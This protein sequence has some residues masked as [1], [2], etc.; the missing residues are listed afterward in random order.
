[1]RHQPSAQALMDPGHV[2]GH[3]LGTGRTHG[4]AT[5]SDGSPLQQLPAPASSPPEIPSTYLLPGDRFPSTLAE[6][7]LV[8]LHVLHSRVTRRLDTE[9]RTDPSGPHPVTLDRAQ[10]LMDE[11]DTRQEFLQGSGP[12]P[13]PVEP[14][15]RGVDTS[16][17]QAWDAGSGRAPGRNTAGSRTRRRASTASRRP[18]EHSDVLFSHRGEAVCGIDVRI[19]DLDRLRSGDRIEIWQD[20]Q[21]HCVGIVELAAP[22]L[23]VLWIRDA[24]DGYRRMLHLHDAVLRYHLPAEPRRP[25]P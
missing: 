12:D 3:V 21:L 14:A 2:S 4:F 7:D 24:L 6:L 23:G 22:A 9:Y 5:A 15:S 20:E 17:E 16:P 25:A 11:L 10:E 8:E 18:E 19:E 1:M 13:V